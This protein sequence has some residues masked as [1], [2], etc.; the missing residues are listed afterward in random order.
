MVFRSSVW[1]GV[2][3]PHHFLVWCT[4]LGH[5]ASGSHRAANIGTRDPKQTL[6]Q[7]RNLNPMIPKP[8]PRL[9]QDGEDLG[10]QAQCGEA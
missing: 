9:G 3:D 7:T 10:W 1:V 6:N 4:T 2:G 5:R 8:P